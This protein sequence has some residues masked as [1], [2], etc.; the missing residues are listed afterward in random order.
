MLSSY[1]FLLQATRVL[2]VN[3]CDEEDLIMIY[4]FTLAIDNEVLNRYN[5]TNSLLIYNSD[6]EL[7]V[8]ILDALIYAFIEIEE[9]EKCAVLKKKKEQ[10]LKIMNKK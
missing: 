4:N 6:L 5:V 1:N 7:Y 3:D 10:C 2:Q 8:E 9:Y